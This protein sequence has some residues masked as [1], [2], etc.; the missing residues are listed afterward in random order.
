M[1]KTIALIAATLIAAPLCLGVAAAQETL[2]LATGEAVYRERIALP[3]DAYL[4]VE[5]RREDGTLIASARTRADGRQVPLPFSVR[6]PVDG[7]A[8]TVAI[9][10]GGEANWRSDPVEIPAGEAPHQ[11][12]AV[13]LRS[14]APMGRI[15]RLA[16][17][18]EIV[19]L[20]DGGGA[21]MMEA[22]GERFR[23]SPARAASGARY[24]AENAKE[25][26]FWNKGE[27]S[28]VSVRGEVLPECRAAPAP[29]DF[30]AY[31]NEPGW[32]IEIHG[33]RI[34]LITEYGASRREAALPPPSPEPGAT[35]YHIADWE[36]E[37][38]IEHSICRDPATGLPYPQSVSARIGTSTG[39]SIGDQALQACGGAPLDL[40]T[41]GEWVVEDIAGRGVVDPSHATLLFGADG[42]VSGGATCNRY[43]ASFRLTGEGLD[44]GPA[45]MT[46]KTCPPA[47]ME[48][49][50]R[51]AAALEA[52]TGFDMDETG[53]LL[54][55]SAEGA[56]LLLARR[57]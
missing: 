12:G 47:L 49:E 50:N 28:L 22:R 46:R 41:G 36:A 54:L 43:S 25:T 19:S 35:F 51:F 3:P 53:A 14:L 17:G 20:G 52:A 5:T 39:A 9:L 7:G 23:L 34:V 26:F 21:L 48:Q 32:G 13:L 6:A 24:D 45:A 44:F 29:A 18:A 42:R 55:K 37:I 40:L 38:R 1:L 2:R 16:C 30:S 15:S 8:L 11:A 33:G 4:V 57:P 56:P 10:Q 27:I 31:G